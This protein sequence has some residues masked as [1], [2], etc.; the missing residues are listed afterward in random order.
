M[1]AEAWMARD[2]RTPEQKKQ[3][4]L[5]HL[6]NQESHLNL[7]LVVLREKIARV[8]NGDDA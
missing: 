5:R 1:I 2:E 3:D 4:R 8:E 7:Q 6:R